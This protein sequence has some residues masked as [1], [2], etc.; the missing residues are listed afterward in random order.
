M[1][2]VLITGASSGIGKACASHLH[3]KGYRVYGT[4]RLAMDPNVAP[5]AADD[6]G[7]RL[8]P[9]DVTDEASIAKAIE[10]VEQIEGRLDVLVNNA[11][12]GLAGTVEDTMTTEAHLQLDTNFLG[13][14]RVC[15][16]VIPL[17]RRQGSGLIVNISS[18]A[19][20]VGIPF[21]SFYSASK[22]AVEG[23]SQALRG[24]IGAY[25]ISVVVIRPGDLKTSFTVNR[26]KIPPPEGSPNTRAFETALE[27]ME[28]DEANGPSPETVAKRLGQL[29]ASKSPPLCTTVGSASQRFLISLRLILPISLFERALRA[30]YRL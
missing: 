26:K 4:S 17:M 14:V 20:V 21:Q 7:F 19:G 9:M 27:I 25:G 16:A 15:R 28:Q 6:G 3:H 24:E 1:K 12:Y 23:F 30:Y 11:G 5:A 8:L 29:I 10:Y 2:V 22:F 18:M 13:T